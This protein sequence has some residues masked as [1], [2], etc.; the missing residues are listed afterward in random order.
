MTE[1]ELNKLYKNQLSS[2]GTQS[3]FDSI[4]FPIIRNINFGNKEK[5]EEIK[6][7]IK[8]KNREN[9]I[10]SVEEGVDYTESKIEDHPDYPSSMGLLGADLIA[11]K[12][13]PA[14]SGDIHID[15]QYG[16]INPEEKS[17]CSASTT[18]ESFR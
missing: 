1:E 13:L 11:V 18:N 14:P 9:K 6:S 3:N 16:S 17:G 4:A 12:P 2:M 10:K 7:E 15:Y 8:S 5:L